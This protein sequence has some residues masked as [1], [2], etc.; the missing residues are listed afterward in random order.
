VRGRCVVLLTLGIVAAGSGGGA[1]GQD[2]VISEILYDP[3]GVNTGRQRVELQ[4]VGA[5]TVELGVSGFWLRVPPTAWRFPAAATL[6][7]GMTLTVHLNRSGEDL[8][9]EFFTGTAGMRSLR[10]SDAVALYRSNL[11]QD[12]DSLVHFVEWGAPGQGGEDVAVAAGLWPEGDAVDTAALRAGSSLA[13]IGPNGDGTLGDNGDTS[14]SW[15]I[16]GTPSLGARHDGCT[17]SRPRS[18][19][20]IEEI[21]LG[22]I[23]SDDGVTSSSFLELRNVGDALEDL[24]GTVVVL[25]GESAYEFAVGTLLGPGEQLLL[26]LAADGEDTDFVRYTGAD[27]FRRLGLVDSLSVHVDGV[28]LDDAAEDPSR[29]LYFVQWGAG[30]GPFESAAVAAGAWRDG[31]FVDSATLHPDGALVRV[32]DVAGPGGWAIDNTPTPGID[33]DALPGAPSVVVNEVLLDPAGDNV[34]R[35]VIELANIGTVEVD[36]SGRALCH[37]TADAGAGGLTCYELPAGARIPPGEFVLI[38]AGAAGDDSA[39]E[40]FAPDL[41]PF[42]RGLGEIGLFMTADPTNANN[43]VDYLRWGSPDGGE[44]GQ[45]AASVELWSVDGAID[46][47]RL[48]DGASIAYQ[49]TGDSPGDYR[50]DFTPSLGASNDSTGGNEPFRRGDCNDDGAVDISDSIIT[51]GFLFLGEAAPECRNACDSNDD[52]AVDIS[53]P[54]YLLNFLFRGGASPPP[55]VDEC[56]RDDEPAGPGCDAYVSC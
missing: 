8:G 31:E 7:P 32:G 33:N 51:F 11:F 2:V 30:G 19:I 44:I 45:L 27:A 3:A 43:M 21:G 14:D 42:D 54:V 12:P 15:C 48:R 5:E 55:P 28:G 40:F 24:G 50:I 34:G 39:L 53:D 56:G 20:V 9:S 41:G 35:Q 49:G 25:A 29:V 47:T 36:V 1:Y 13:W 23:P 52:G 22:G 37:E 4:N 10:S 18:H 17:V 16:D 6:A 26:L 46:V 38:H